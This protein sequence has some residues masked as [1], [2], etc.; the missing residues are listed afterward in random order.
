MCSFNNNNTLILFVEEKWKIER[1]CMIRNNIDH[2]RKLVKSS[3]KVIK[4]FDQQVQQKITLTSFS[5]NFYFV[6][7]FICLLLQCIQKFYFIKFYNNYFSLF[8][9]LIYHL[10]IQFI[11]YF[12]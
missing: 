4:N 10:S 12:H 6:H 3:N 9:F 7:L 2:P 8:S 5:I 11:F 1:D